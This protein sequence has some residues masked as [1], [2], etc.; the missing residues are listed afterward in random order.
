MFYVLPVL[1]TSTRYLNFKNS[2]GSDVVNGFDYI[3][4]LIMFIVFPLTAVL[5][6]SA[7]SVSVWFGHLVITNFQIKMQFFIFAIFSLVLT[8]LVLNF[9]FSTQEVYDYVITL[10]GFLYWISLLFYANSLFTVIFTI[11]VLSSLVF[12]YLVV[13]TF[14]SAFF[15]RN[16]DLSFGNFFNTQMPY[17]H[18]K[19]IIFYFWVS[20]IS[21]LNLFF[22]IIL[23]YTKL[24]TFDWYVLEYVLSFFITTNSFKSILGLGVIWF[25]LI[26]SIFLKCAIAP[27]FL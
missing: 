5:L 6:W 21:S 16:I 17:N 26:M 7:P 15:Y 11:E 25:I 12:L 3:P 14:S 18:L 2:A 24:L 13:S 19:S 8:T 9:Y 10:Y 27:L 23:L 1:S 4:V 22:F 20:L